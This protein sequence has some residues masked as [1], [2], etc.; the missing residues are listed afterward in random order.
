MC[1]GFEDLCFSVLGGQGSGHT[2]LVRT[3]EEV[4]LGVLH[5]LDIAATG[6]IYKFSLYCRKCLVFWC[7]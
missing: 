6:L 3:A 7:V 4:D 2:I 5:L 1:L